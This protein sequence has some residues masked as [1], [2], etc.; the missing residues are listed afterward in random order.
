MPGKLSGTVT[1]PAVNG[2][3]QFSD[4]CIDQPSTPTDGYTLRATAADLNLSSES[5][6]F[7][8]GLF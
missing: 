6:R 8:I 1:V 5:A 4:L 7:S 3:A 2:V